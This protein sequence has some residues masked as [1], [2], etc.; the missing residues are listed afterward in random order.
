MIATLSLQPP[1]DQLVGVRNTLEDLGQSAPVEDPKPVVP[2]VVRSE[3]RCPL[4]D[5]LVVRVP[6]PLGE[7]NECEAATAA[8]VRINVDD[9]GPAQHSAE[10]LLDGCQVNR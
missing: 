4:G 2:L 3:Q 5:E 1:T 6:V 9:A 7:P 10:T 8:S